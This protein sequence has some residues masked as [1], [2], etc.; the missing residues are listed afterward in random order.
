M[1]ASQVSITHAMQTDSNFSGN[2]NVTANPTALADYASAIAVQ[3]DGKIVVGG[4]SNEL[5]DSRITLIRYN[6]DG[7][8]DS[9]F[10]VSGMVQ[11]DLTEDSDEL[12]S[13]VIQNDGSILVGFLGGDT[14]IA[15]GSRNIIARYT[16]GGVLDD[17]FV[18]DGLLIVPGT[19]TNFGEL[20]RL[21]DGSML[22]C[23][24]MV[25]SGDDRAYVAKFD[26]SGA[27]D[28]D[29]G[30]N[31]VFS[32]DLAHEAEEFLDIEVL[33]DGSIIAA[34]W[35]YQTFPAPPR[36][37]KIAV[38]RLSVTGD[39]DGS[40]GTGGVF[41]YP[42]DFLDN[43]T[44]MIKLPDDDVLIMYNLITGGSAILRLHPDGEFD[45]AFG[46]NGVLE[47]NWDATGLLSLP[48]RKIMV[49]GQNPSDDAYFRVYKDDGSL[50][51]SFG[52]NGTQNL[53]FKVESRGDA[54][55][56][57]D[58]GKILMAGALTPADF[59]YKFL[60]MRFN[61]PDADMDG[62]MDTDNCPNDFNPGQNDV[63]GVGDDDDDDTGS[64]EGGGG[65]GGGFTDL[66]F[67]FMLLL[68]AGMNRRQ[69]RVRL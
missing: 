57:Q 32:I 40:F 54:L 67:I 4:Y 17:T 38:V 65:G 63:C 58:D 10:G 27:A 61:D 2:G 20:E 26:S 19:E 62:V 35:T 44:T 7:T 31:G 6:A 21:N 12:D 39:Q 66:Y 53:S 30:T 24:N 16:A 29:F 13:V 55:L 46:D 37:S 64:S 68:F 48:N 14:T 69:P 28:D 25:D 23:G 49:T 5:T 50:D 43:F 51:T 45:T 36:L 41:T 9:D 3:A 8:V 1:T 42:I 18:D 22:V 11:D 56:L 52:D 59:N 34:G 15:L 47:I 33:S 60:T